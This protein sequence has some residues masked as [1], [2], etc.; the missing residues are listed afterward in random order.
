MIERFHRQLKDALRCLNADSDWNEHFPLILLG[1][2]TLHEEDLNAAPAR[3]VYG[4]TLTLP[5]D[6]TAPT[7]E[8]DSEVEPGEFVQQ[9]TERMKNIKSTLPRSAPKTPEY[10]PKDLNCEYVFYVLTRID[11]RSSDRTLD[12][13][14]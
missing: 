12:P 5:P 14:R 8:S 9:L 10:I 3:L 4:Q 13:T 6:F 11:H 2:R 7:T 1:F